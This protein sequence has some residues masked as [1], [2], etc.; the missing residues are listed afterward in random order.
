MKKLLTLLLCAALLLSTLCVFAGASQEQTSTADTSAATEQG[1]TTTLPKA[2]NYLFV[3]P[4]MGYASGTLS[5]DMPEQSNATSFALYWG[6]ENGVRI[7]GMK[8]LMTGD[9]I[10]PT[11][12]VPPS[13]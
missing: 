12:S 1:G 3:N 6:D 8:P 9:I 7:P 11:M 2:A 13:E 10:S 5:F 4:G